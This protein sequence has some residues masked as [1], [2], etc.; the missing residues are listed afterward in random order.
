MVKIKIISVGKIKQGY[1]QSM[2]DD[3]I[4]R[5]KSN[6]KIEHIIVDTANYPLKLNDT[7][8]EQI[9][10]TEGVNILKKIGSKDYVIALNLNQTEY[11]SL[12]FSQYI[13]NLIDQSIGTI[14]FI[15]GGSYGLGTNVLNRAN[16]Q[17]TL[18]KM[19]LIH[20]MAIV[21][22]LEQLY[23]GVNIQNNTPYHK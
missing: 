11:D 4:K 2:I 22:L 13:Q 8:I 18:S 20:E 10:E 7:I 17:I 23:R 19:T 5:L 3:Y 6:Y 14:T 9:K 16:S 21:F 15:I 1:F 12:K